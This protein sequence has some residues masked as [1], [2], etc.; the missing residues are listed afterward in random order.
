MVNHRQEF[1][2]QTMSSYKESGALVWPQYI[3]GLAGAGGAFASGLALGWPAPVQPRLVDEG[4][5]FPITEE[6]FAWV[7]SIITIGKI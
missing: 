4:Q 3:A 1:I 2:Q 7:A 6:E 5:Y